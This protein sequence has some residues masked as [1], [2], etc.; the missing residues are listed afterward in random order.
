M[1]M[2]MDMDMDVHL[3]YSVATTQIGKRIQ[4]GVKRC[5]RCAKELWAM[6][7]SMRLRNTNDA[8]GCDFPFQGPNCQEISRR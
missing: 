1:D 8:S 2:D 5:K 6:A 7:I 4:S 3:L